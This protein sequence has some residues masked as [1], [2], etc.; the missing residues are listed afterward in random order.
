MNNY[1]FIKKLNGD[2]LMSI[3][4]ICPFCGK[5]NQ[6]NHY[7][8]YENDSIEELLNK[9]DFC[10]C[11]NLIEIEYSYPI[12]QA[13]DLVLT[14]EELYNIC[15]EKDKSNYLEM[16]KLLKKIDVIVSDNDLIKYIDLFES[17]KSKYKD[18]KPE[19]YNVISDE[20]ENKMFSKYSTDYN[21]ID[22]I[23][24]SSW[25]CLRNKF[26][27]PLIIMIASI[28]E[29]LFNDY[30]SLIV[31]KKLGDRGGK[32]LLSKYEYAGINECMDICNAFL[33]QPLKIK[34][35]SIMSGFY[36]K[37]A[38]LRYDRNS[39]VHDN[40]KYISKKRISDLYN[41]ISNSI[42]VFSNLKS[43]YI[44][45]LQQKKFDKNCSIDNTSYIKL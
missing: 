7:K 15:K 38:T 40:T 23:L 12:L 13:Q 8:D 43:Q 41:L 34:M 29:I 18:N 11:G 27:K 37:W 26:R 39:I 17:V 16:K 1:R 31:Y 4:Y 6:K 3:V 14:V 2:F 45:T 22:A 30:F 42:L 32:E 9:K 21:I 20:Y 19:Y 36:D 10:T 5:I 25:V 35:D 24:S 28:V 33:D 44:C